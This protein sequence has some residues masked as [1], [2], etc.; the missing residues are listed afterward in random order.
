MTDNEGALGRAYLNLSI[1][2]EAVFNL[3]V[4]GYLERGVQTAYLTWTGTSAANIDVYR[5]GLKVAT[6]PNNGSYTDRTN[7][8]GCGS[9]TFR[10]CE[11]GGTACSYMVT[12]YFQ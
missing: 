5:N 2:G 7:Q 8:R 11:T 9:K 6:T 4:T 12:V 10:V 3:N 1:S